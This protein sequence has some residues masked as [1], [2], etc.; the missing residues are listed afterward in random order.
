MASKENFHPQ[1]K[2]AAMNNQKA[3]KAAIKVGNCE[4]AKAIIA[5]MKE[6][7]K[8]CEVIV[9]PAPKASSK[10]PEFPK[11]KSDMESLVFYMK[12]A[13]DLAKYALKL[14]EIT[15]ECK[16][17]L[18]NAREQE[19]LAANEANAAAEA[20]AKLADSR[21]LFWMRIRHSDY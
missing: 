6:L 11:D 4:E 13:E 15:D 19:R 7:D 10:K 5:C 8:A 16:R 3:A 18:E 21:S 2:A 12:H 17:K 14:S 20:F 1:S 9:E